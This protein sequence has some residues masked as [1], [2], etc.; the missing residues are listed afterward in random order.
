MQ[1]YLDNGDAKNRIEKYTEGKIQISGEVFDSHLLLMPNLQQ[2]WDGIVNNDS[3]QEWLKL[4]PE[5]IILGT[6]SKA[7]FY[8]NDLFLP[9]YTQG[10]GIEIMDT[11]SACRT[12][13][14]L[15]SDMRQVL[16]C[17]II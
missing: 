6:G 5:L 3:V 14:V 12:Y 13:T 11:K 8:N 10:I 7:I 17:L 1:L 4:K 2:K 15:M 16:A 9:L